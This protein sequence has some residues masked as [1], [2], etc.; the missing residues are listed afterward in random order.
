M[1]CRTENAG[2]RCLSLCAYAQWDAISLLSKVHDHSVASGCGANLSYS[3][4]SVAINSL[5]SVLDLVMCGE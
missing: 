3:R 2:R 5:G 1:G 4:Y